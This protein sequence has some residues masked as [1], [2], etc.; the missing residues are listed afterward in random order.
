MN[1]NIAFYTITVEKT[2][3]YV[4]GYTRKAPARGDFL[5]LFEISD[6]DRAFIENK[7]RENILSTKDSVDIII[8]II[9]TYYDK[10]NC[11]KSE[12]GIY[13][14]KYYNKVIVRRSYNYG[15]TKKEI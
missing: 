4:S 12:N 3:W 13:T 2:G 10:L 5:A 6:V 1:T 9:K 15:K 14:F 11:Y 8:D 7:I